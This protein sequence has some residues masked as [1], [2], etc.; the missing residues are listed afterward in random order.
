[1][2][3]LRPVTS[4]RLTATQRLAVW[5]RSVVLPDLSRLAPLEQ[6]LRWYTPSEPSA[7]W[8]HLSA[9]EILAH[10]DGHLAGCRRMRGRRCLRRGLL[11]FYFLRLAGHPAVLHVGVFARPQGRTLAHCWTTCS[12]A[13][14]ELI[15]DPPQAPCVPVLAW[16]GKLGELDMRIDL[17][18]SPSLAASR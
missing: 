4:Q 6:L 12:T 18:S 10:I 17:S 16:H 1:M 11:A 8:L 15:D 5:T 3:A 2:S 7:A 13:A 9:R 14:G